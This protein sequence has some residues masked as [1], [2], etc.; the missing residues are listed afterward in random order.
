M[1]SPCLTNY[2]L[3]REDVPGSGY[4][5]PGILYFR[6]QLEVTGEFHAPAALVSGKEPHTHWIEPV[7]TTWIG[8]KFCL[9]RVSNSDPSTVQL[10]VAV[11]TA[12]QQYVRQ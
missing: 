10:V 1:V 4:I 9:Y 3:H 2:A 6:L 11:P 12:L 5:D 8:E 7:S